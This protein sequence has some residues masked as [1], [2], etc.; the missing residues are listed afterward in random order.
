MA[1]QRALMAGRYKA[2]PAH[3]SA[4]ARA[5]VAQLLV[6]DPEQRASLEVREGE[7]RGSGSGFKCTVYNTAC[8]QEVASLT[9]DRLLM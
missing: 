9:P 2:L 6:V 4:G 3:N 5:V 1:T 7:S 8:F